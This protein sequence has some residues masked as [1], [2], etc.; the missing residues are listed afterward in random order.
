MSSDEGT[1]GGE[2][3]GLDAEEIARL[4]HQWIRSIL[5]HRYPFLLVDRV[6]EL[7]PERSIVALKNVTQNEEFFQGHFPGKPIMPGVLVIEALAQA[8]GL[9][10][11]YDRP[12]L[13]G[14]VI[15]FV[16]IENA[17]FRNPVTPGDQVRLHVEILRARRNHARFACRATIGDLV[18]VEC[19]ASSMIGREEK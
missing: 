17:K 12:E 15:Y 13:H 5:P 2:A 10:L 11:L 9:L 1:T 14:R 3:S 4:D 16:G 7:V 8:A 6:V 19:V 18:A